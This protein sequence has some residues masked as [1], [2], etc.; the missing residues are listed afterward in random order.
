MRGLQERLAEVEA[1]LHAADLAQQRFARFDV[2]LDGDLLCPRCWIDNEV[3]AALTPMPSKTAD[4]ITR[5]RKCG[6]EITIPA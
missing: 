4:D 5:C 3:R 1:Q 2:T 6:F